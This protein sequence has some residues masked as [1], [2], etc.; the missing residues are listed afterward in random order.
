MQMGRATFRR[1]YGRN[2]CERSCMDELY[3]RAAVWVST[4]TPALEAA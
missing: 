2:R 4:L 3:S 1:T